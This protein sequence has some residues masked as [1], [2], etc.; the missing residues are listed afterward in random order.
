[1][2]FGATPDD[3][4]ERV[5]PHDPDAVKNTTHSNLRNRILKKT[6]D[7]RRKH[8]GFGHAARPIDGAGNVTQNAQAV[9]RGGNGGRPPITDEQLLFVSS[10]IS[11]SRFIY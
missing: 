2:V 1:M 10:I 8:G 4:A 9:I 6:Q 7:Y 3:M 5:D 11:S